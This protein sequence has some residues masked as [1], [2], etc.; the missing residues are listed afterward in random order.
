MAAIVDQLLLPMNSE[1]TF[2][3]KLLSWP[4]LQKHREVRQRVHC[5]FSLLLVPLC[6]LQTCCW[7][8]ILMLS[9]PIVRHTTITTFLSG[10][11]CWRTCLQGSAPVTGG[12]ELSCVQSIKVSTLSLSQCLSLTPP[13]PSETLLHVVTFTTPKQLFSILPSTGDVRF[14]LPVIEL[15]CKQFLAKRLA[16]HLNP[17][18]FLYL[19]Y[20]CIMVSTLFEIFKHSYHTDLSL[21][22]YDVIILHHCVF[23]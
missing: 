11:R 23:L 2:S 21:N 8:T 6:R 10:H 1:A 12:Q 17:L 18:W 15:S 3:L 5:F 19:L 16:S 22:I 20:Y 9:Y 4:H 13:T 14:F 7:I